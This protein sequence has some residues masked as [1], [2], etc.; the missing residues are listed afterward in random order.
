MNVSIICLSLNYAKKSPMKTF[1]E[2]ISKLCKWMFNILIDANYKDYKLR[3][4]LE[5][6]DTEI[7]RLL[8]KY[9]VDKKI[10]YDQLAS[11]H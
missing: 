1:Y 11:L 6:K 2:T 5:K 7:I 9:V 10:I 3:T 4:A 8:I